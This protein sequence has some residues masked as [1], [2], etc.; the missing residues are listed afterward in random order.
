MRVK[1]DLGVQTLIENMAQNEYRLETER[2]KRVVFGVDKN[3]V[4]L[5]NQT[6]MSK[7]MEELTKPNIDE[8]TDGGTNQ[9]SASHKYGSSSIPTLMSTS[10]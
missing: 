1:N 2:G 4:I 10:A 6:L 8:Q 3:S 9:T 5:A 7:Q